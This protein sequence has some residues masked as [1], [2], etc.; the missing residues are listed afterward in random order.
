M[1]LLG[2]GHFPQCTYKNTCQLG[3]KKLNSRLGGCALVGS[4]ILN[5]AGGEE[6]G[7]LFP[8]SQQLRFHQVHAHPMPC[9]NYLA[10]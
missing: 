3:G 9:L 10:A 2:G 5:M 7:R 4:H 1:Q 8:G 6:L